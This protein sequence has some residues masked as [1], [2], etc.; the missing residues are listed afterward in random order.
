M[1]RIAGGVFG[2][3]PL[4]IV[5]YI[6]ALFGTVIWRERTRGYKVKAALWLVIGCGLVLLFR[7]ML[8]TTVVQDVETVAVSLLQI[9]IALVLA[10][11][12]VYRLAD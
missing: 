11:F 5:F 2:L 8:D 6:P 12:T 3:V 4:I 10:F 9:A 1:L 7:L